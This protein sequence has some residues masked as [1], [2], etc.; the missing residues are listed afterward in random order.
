VQIRIDLGDGIKEY[1]ASEKLGAPLLLA[2]EGSEDKFDDFVSDIR[3]SFRESAKL[4][5]FDAS[6]YKE[7]WTKIIED[8]LKDVDVTDFLTPE[9]KKKFEDNLKLIGGKP[10]ITIGAFLDGTAPS[11]IPS[12]EG[13]GLTAKNRFTNKILN[14][15]PIYLEDVLGRVEIVED[16]DYD[17]SDL[18]SKG[19]ENAFRFKPQIEVMFKDLLDEKMRALKQIGITKVDKKK[20]PMKT[21]STTELP[22]LGL[23]VQK[24]PKF[25]ED[26]EKQ[27]EEEEEVDVSV[28]P[29]VASAK[30]KLE[31]TF[32][33]TYTSEILSK[34]DASSGEKSA[35]EFLKIMAS[36]VEDDL[37]KEIEKMRPAV[38]Q[39][40]SH[41]ENLMVTITTIPSK[42]SLAFPEG[43]DSTTIKFKFNIEYDDA[44]TLDINPVDIFMSAQ[45]IAR[46]G[47]GKSDTARRAK[48]FIGSYSR[49]KQQAEK[50]QT[51]QYYP[52]VMEEITEIV[53]RVRQLEKMIKRQG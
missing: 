48:E 4:E 20:F 10:D 14:N 43:K 18:D 24:N 47:E 15:Q 2:F 6:K 26:V 3:D 23:K 8:S 51:G 50:G 52:E 27:E 53:S 25:Y 33:Y 32:T 46:Q 40:S 39:L 30:Y 22:L 9:S 45:D 36:E 5:K 38:T 21:K 13:Y 35:I 1:A 49:F 17:F 42:I 37:L 11:A 41:F 28:T 16:I 12:G 34:L 31:P 7:L 29:T 44:Y 19:A